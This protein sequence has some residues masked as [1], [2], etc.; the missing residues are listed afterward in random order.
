MRD[1]MLDDPMS[2]LKLRNKG[3]ATPF[4]QLGFDYK[5]NKG[6]AIVFFEPS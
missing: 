1:D 6:N 3:Y 4:T 2:E 5:A